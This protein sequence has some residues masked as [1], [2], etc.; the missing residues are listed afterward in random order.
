[1]RVTVCELPDAA[2]ELG[3]V[4]PALRDHC[5]TERSELLLLPEL[6]FHPWFGT[7][8][9]FDP[10]VWAAAEEAH[11]SGIAR[12]GELAPAA[13]LATAPAVRG[14]E[15]V[16]EA[17]IWDA[18]LGYRAAHRKHHLPD[19]AG[20]WE[21]HWY[22][23]GD[24]RF[25]P[26]RVGEALV[27]FLVCTEIWSLHRARAYGEAGV[28]ILATPRLTERATADK[29]LACGRTAAVYA[30]AY[31]LS[32]NRSAPYGGL[33]WI[34]DPDGEVLATTGPERPFATVEIDLARAEQAKGT[35]PRYTF[36]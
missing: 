9:D 34:V 23:R 13:V 20:V 2:G 26:A 28:H 14:G 31:S 10:E 25:E 27:G 29:W 30:G 5:R 33:G 12:L 24:G 11:R 8:P 16:N 19:E 4:W 35:Y 3:R 21:A 36:G 32:S 15:R 17:F 6:P 18:G 7:T 1:M 22:G